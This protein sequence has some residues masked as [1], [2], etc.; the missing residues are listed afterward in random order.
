MAIVALALAATCAAQQDRGPARSP[1][2]TVPS[3]PAPEQQLFKLLNLERQHAGVSLLEW[4]PNLA[5]AAQTHAQKMARAGD[6][7]HR[8]NGEPELTQRASDAGTL[9]KAVAENVAL[10]GTPEE[11]HLALMNSPG[12][13]A[14]ILSS[15]YNAVG[16]GVAQAGNELYVTEDFAQVVPAYSADQFRRGVVD[17]FNKLRRSHR[18]RA[19]TARG[20]P[21]LDRE[22]C[23]GRFDPGSV[24]AGQI[25]AARATSFTAVQP[26]DLPA[27]MENSAADSSLQRM[28][29]GV[30]FR[31]DPANGFA[32]FWVIAVFFSDQSGANSRGSLL[33]ATR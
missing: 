27:V 11:A 3:P 15:Q 1:T 31:P 25:G 17:A 7:S 8:F 23:T 16:I 22:A 18:I 9:F 26:W 32:Q 2:G 5:D 6:I 30:C 24:L 4:N 12:H 28:N 13:R 20:D 10:A 19:I 14:N 21:A 33:P 29:L